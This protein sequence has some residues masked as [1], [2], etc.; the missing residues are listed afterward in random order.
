MQL[1]DRVRSI[2]SGWTGTVV[3]RP[4][5]WKELRTIGHKLDTDVVYVRWDERVEKMKKGKENRGDFDIKEAVVSS[6]ISNL[7]IIEQ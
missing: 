4:K 7:L 2:S 5:H 1:G 6:K 3:A